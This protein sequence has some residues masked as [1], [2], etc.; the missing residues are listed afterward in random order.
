MLLLYW[1]GD[2]HKHKM[3][4]RLS[5]D[6]TRR[7]WM[8]K[9][10]NLS[11]N[12]GNKLVLK[13]INY[14]IEEGKVNVL[15]GKN[16]C[17]KTT[18]IK[19]MLNILTPSAGTIKYRGKELKHIGQTYYHQVNAVLENSH[20]N[21]GYLTG[22]GNID[23]LKSLYDQTIDDE[24]IEQLFKD[25]GL[26]SARYEKVSTYSRGMKQKLAIICALLNDAQLLFLDEP[27]L[28]LDYKSNLELIK[29]IKRMT[30]TEGK[31]VILTTH[32]VDVLKSLSDRIIFIADGGVRFEGDYL[33]FLSDK[34]IETRLL[35]ELQ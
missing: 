19:M 15:L 31:T 5:N 14:Q 21:Y 12:F 18:L 4:D 9:V 30:E 34:S 32:Q 26:L 28:G 1:I 29:Q 13:Q 11:K 6:V 2:V 8:L 24:K 20:N 35:E 3:N 7:Y 16:G 10:E 33:A 27:T 23:Y 25:F 22:Q 17:G